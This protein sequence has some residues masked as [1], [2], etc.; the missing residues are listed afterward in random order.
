MIIYFYEYKSDLDNYNCASNNII[1]NNNVQKYC[2]NLQYAL[3][4]CKDNQN[5]KLDLENNKIKSSTAILLPDN[6][7]QTPNFRWKFDLTKDYLLFDPLF[8]DNILLNTMNKYEIYFVQIRSHA[9]VNQL[10][11][12]YDIFVVYL[13][14]CKIENINNLICNINNKNDINLNENNNNEIKICLLNYFENNNEI[15]TE[16]MSYLKYNRCYGFVTISKNTFVDL[17][18]PKTEQIAH[19]SQNSTTQLISENNSNSQQDEFNSQP[20]QHS[21]VNHY[22]SE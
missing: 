22:N 6:C 8:N 20:L 13:N 3:L 12:I 5:N 15:I 9:I 17:Q 19:I 11:R 4:I 14:K 10:P 18:N 7:E 2:G 1:I 16:I 21:I